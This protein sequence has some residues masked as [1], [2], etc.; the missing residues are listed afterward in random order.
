CP[1]YSGEGNISQSAQFTTVADRV[2]EEAGDNQRTN[3]ITSHP[4][5]PISS[6]HSLFPSPDSSPNPLEY[7]IN[8]RSTTVT[9]IS[10]DVEQEAECLD[11]VPT[12]GTKRARFNFTIE[13]N[14]FIWR[15]YLV[16]TNLEKQTKKFLD[17][18]YTEFTDK[19][20]DIKITKQKIAAQRRDILK[21]K[22]LPIETLEEIKCEVAQI[23]QTPSDSLQQTHTTNTTNPITPQ[24]SDSTTHSILTNMRPPTTKS[25][26]SRQRLQWTK[27]INK[28]LLKCYYIV[29][30]N[31]TNLTGYRPQLRNKFIETYP[32]LNFITEQRLADQI[33]LIIHS[34]YLQPTERENIKRQLTEDNVFLQTQPINNT[35][36]IRRSQNHTNQNESNID[37]SFNNLQEETTTQTL[38]NNSNTLN[39]NISSNY[40]TTITE[41]FTEIDGNRNGVDASPNFEFLNLV[42]ATKPSKLRYVIDELA[43]EHGHEVIRLPHYDCQYNTIELI[44]AQIKG[45]AA[46][47]NTEPP[48][49]AAIMMTLLQTASAEVTTE[50]WRKVVA[51]T[52][53]IILQDFERDVRIDNINVQYENIRFSRVDSIIIIITSGFVEALDSYVMQTNIENELIISLSADSS[54]EDDNTNNSSDSSTE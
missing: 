17:K 54:D 8:S 20:P 48:F 2:E 50:D 25:G 13:M 40:P 22:L 14:K 36:R 18:L 29:T 49:S 23:L 39:N 41:T 37:N 42:K 43:L 34:N 27:E 35:R 51:K 38:N 10:V 45:H 30:N 16:T 9:P 5:S 21:N 53:K 28:E 6:T 31:E 15:T 33:R 7:H 12:I 47:N 44:W 3:I 11:L 24:T 26:K 46:R 52:K 1:T 19:Y 4:T 32:D